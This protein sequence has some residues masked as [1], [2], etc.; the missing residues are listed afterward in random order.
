MTETKLP[1][2]PGVDLAVR[3]DAAEKRFV[4]R[5]TEDVEPVLEANKQLQ[6]LGPGVSRSK[7]FKHVASIPV[8]LLEQWA[9]EDG[10]LIHLMRPRERTAYLMKKLRDPQY[11]HLRTSTGRI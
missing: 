10:V 11:R 3:Y 9:K 4:F 7:A 2:N 8:A 5:R 6:N 1:S